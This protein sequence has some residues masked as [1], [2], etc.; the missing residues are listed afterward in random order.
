[1][2]V[3]AAFVIIIIIF[4]EVSY[5]SSMMMTTPLRVLNSLDNTNVF[6]LPGDARVSLC[7]CVISRNRRNL[8]RMVNDLDHAFRFTAGV[9]NASFIVIVVSKNDHG[10]NNNKDVIQDEEEGEETWNYNNN[11]NN[12]GIPPPPQMNWSHG[13]IHMEWSGVLDRLN[14]YGV[15]S[16]SSGGGE[17]QIVFFIEDHMEVSTFCFLWI[18]SQMGAVIASSPQAVVLVGGGDFNNPSGLVFSGEQWDALVF[19]RQFEGVV[20]GNTDDHHHHRQN[21]NNNNGLKTVDV[22]KSL[23][24]MTHV[25]VIFSTGMY[26]EQFIRS[27]YQNRLEPEAE[28]SKLVRTWGFYEY[29]QLISSSSYSD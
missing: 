12:D 3:A 26:G 25:S 28:N 23:M 15:G 18:I 21:N 29:Q 20:N 19:Q 22:L 6:R 1:L 8:I 14:V 10:N 17:D 5:A 13:M 9:M 2:T 16:S 4:N 24:S 11:N 7:L 27:R